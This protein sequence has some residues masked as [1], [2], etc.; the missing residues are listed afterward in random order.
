MIVLD[1]LTNEVIDD[2]D[3]EY[4]IGDKE[5]S[6][7]RNTT[8]LS[9]IVPKII[10]TNNSNG[11]GI[12]SIT[13]NEVTK[14]V[15]VGL[16]ISYSSE[17]DFPFS[18]GD[19]VLIENINVGIG[20]GISK[21]YNSSDY[22]YSLFT[23]TSIHPNIGGANGTVTYSLDSYVGPGE[24]P[25]TF[26][27]SESAGL[28]TPEKFFPTFNVEIEGGNFNIGEEIVSQTKKGIVENWNSDSGLLAIST[29]EDF[30]IGESIRGISSKTQAEYSKGNFQ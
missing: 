25:G 16:G 4:E 2:V 12:N 15:I 23:L 19:K 3:L 1:A 13:F 7:I 28:I 29:V 17:S 20:T 18:V 9:G 6:I 21:G 24:N 10:P 14:D 26:D 22:K 30:E 27:P 11:V 8:K 5:V